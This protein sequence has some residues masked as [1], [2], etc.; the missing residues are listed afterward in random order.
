MNNRNVSVLTIVLSVGVLQCRVTDDHEMAM[1]A[2]FPL[3]PVVQQ[4]LPDV[5]SLA[6][7]EFIIPRI[8]QPSPPEKN[9][10]IRKVM[11]RVEFDLAKVSIPAGIVVTVATLDK[12]TEWRRSEIESLLQ[13]IRHILLQ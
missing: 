12:S 13:L 7:A 6:I 5:R 10:P 4:D 11:V 8:Q 1:V 3:P 2:E 9:T